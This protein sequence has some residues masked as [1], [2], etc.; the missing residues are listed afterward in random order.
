MLTKFFHV[1]LLL[2]ASHASFTTSA[3][4]NQALLHE[5]R[6]AE[7]KVRDDARKPLQT[8]NFFE[9]TPQSTVVEVWPG[10]GWYTE[11]LAPLLADKGK[12]YAAHFSDK[13]TLLPADYIQKGR[14]DYQTKLASHPV[15]KNVS[16]TEFAPLAG[17]AI[18]PA[19]SADVVLSIRN[20]LYMFDGE[21]SLKH[22]LANFYQALKPGGVL[23]VVAPR[24]P[25]QLLTS[26]WKKTGYVPQQLWLKLAKETGFEF[27]ASNDLLINPKDTA[28]HP[29]G[30]WSLPPS[31]AVDEKDKAKYRAIGE[32]TQMVLKF[33]KPRN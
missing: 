18:A 12:L 11:I 8:L 16:V 23:G 6:T 28:D 10:S 7:N 33:R 3:D 29:S 2:L 27:E 30:I 15:Y 13:F 20:Q 17:I 14:T 22:A 19:A 5:V 26:D 24:L 21:N 1:S 9:V 4:I 32:V 25:D 31:L